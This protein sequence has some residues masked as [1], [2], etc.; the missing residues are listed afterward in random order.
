MNAMDGSET[1][2]PETTSANDGNVPREASD[3]E[4]PDVASAPADGAAEPGDGDASLLR[5]ASDEH[6]GLPDSVPNPSDESGQLADAPPTPIGARSGQLAG[7]PR[8]SDALPHHESHS[9]RRTP[10]ARAARDVNAA[11]PGRPR[12]VPS[13]RGSQGSRVAPGARAVQGLQELAA[14]FADIAGMA[15]HGPRGRDLRLAGRAAGH[16]GLA[17]AAGWLAAVAV[18]LTVWLVSGPDTGGVLGPVRV[19]GQ[20][21]LVAHH[22]S[23]T[24]PSGRIAL[25]PLGFTALLVLALLHA[26]VGPVTRAAQLP[27]AALGSATGYSVAAALITFGAATSDVRPDI[28][29][30]V[31]A[32]ACFGAVVPTATHWRRVRAL[33]VPAWSGDAM[34][35]AACALAVLLG[36]GAAL[37]ATSLVA[38][39]FFGADNSASAS[40]GWPA[41]FADAIGMFLLALAFFPNAIIWA[42]AYLAG[43]GFAV[44]TG[45]GV[46]PFGVRVGAMPSFPLLTAVPTT[47]TYPY[48]L[49]LLAVPVAAGLCL[50]VMV[51][52]ARRTLRDSLRATGTA[53]AGVALVVGLLATLSG[54]PLAS[55]R[56]ATLG[57]S[58]WRAAAGTLVLLGATAG[59]VVVLPDLALAVRRL[60]VRGLLSAGRSRLARLA[61][62]SRLTTL[63]RLSRLTDLTRVPG[64]AVGRLLAVGHR[65]SVRLPAVRVRTSRQ[66]VVEG[67]GVGVPE[68]DDRQQAEE[69]HHALDDLREGREVAVAEVDEA[70][71]TTDA[72]EDGGGDPSPVAPAAADEGHPEP[73]ARV[74]QAADDG[75]PDDSGAR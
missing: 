57:P 28:G 2:G 71:E 64:L 68:E 9:G 32:A 18:C 12:G 51:R 14:E 11:A 66:R 50:G 13:P 16:A 52:L 48:A 41:G 26:A 20:L 40:P 10:T 7:S 33:G 42:T 25:A 38:H 24:I 6:A 69:Q 59:V 43:P 27:Y 70:A 67:P 61:E 53:T 3:R 36:S 4:T 72:E 60:S 45:T 5:A 47:S 34:R 75:E 62:L 15:W 49:A 17:A 30:A 58:G 56:M 44:G 1:P 35:A 23:L 46:G 19:G 37:L 74:D 55:G 8:M 63:T 39:N 65:L 73:Q 22:V 29:Q 54:G 21:W 31:L